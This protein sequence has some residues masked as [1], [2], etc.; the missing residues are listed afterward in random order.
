[1]MLH[2]QFLL[3]FNT[4]QGQNKS[5]DN[6]LVCFNS[7]FQ[8]LEISGGEHL[9]CSPAIL[10]EDIGTADTDKVEKVKERFKVMCFIQCT[11]QVS[12]D[13]CCSIQSFATYLQTNWI[14]TI[15]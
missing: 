13:S 3:F 14:Q 6:Y 1:M 4:R 8:T 5:D 15:K 11:D 10:G 9:M 7:H 2:E 12:S